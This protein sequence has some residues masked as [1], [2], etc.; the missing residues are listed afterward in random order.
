MNEEAQ[1]TADC[2]KFVSSGR[3]GLGS[4]HREALG[5]WVPESPGLLR[6]WNQIWDRSRSP[7]TLPI[8]EAVERS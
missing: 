2:Q 5:H 1:D 8:P 3:S 4:R 6:L 7:P